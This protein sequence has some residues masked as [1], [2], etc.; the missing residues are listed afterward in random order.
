MAETF[1]N[2]HENTSCV[3]DVQPAVQPPTADGAGAISTRGNLTPLAAL[4]H[5][6]GPL[7]QR[8]ELPAGSEF[9]LFRD[10]LEQRR[11]EALAW[12]G[13][14]AASVFDR[15]DCEAFARWATAADILW[16]VLEAEGLLTRTRRRKAR[17][18]YWER[19][20]KRASYYRELLRARKHEKNVS[21]M[22]AAEWIER[23][24]AQQSQDSAGAAIEL[25]RK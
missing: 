3:A 5:G 8:G 11:Q 18:D 25:E 4:K 16:G 6:V 22:T 9:A 1:G 10:V 17:L 12:V 24:S 20:D 15:D 21:D 7:T 23:E 13:G 2:S 14:S 19:C